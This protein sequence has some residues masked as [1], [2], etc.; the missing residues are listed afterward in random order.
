MSSG[1]F[2]FRVEGLAGL[3]YLL[4]SSPD[5]SARQTAREVTATA[6]VEEFRVPM[7]PDARL[8][9]YRIRLLP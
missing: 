5:L 9:A 7:L 1:E 2:A 4:E 3:I 8:Q 6:D